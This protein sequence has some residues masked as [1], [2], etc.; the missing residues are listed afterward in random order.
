MGRVV[1][2][3]MLEFEG[4]AFSDCHVFLCSLCLLSP[5][6]HHLH[7]VSH[8]AVPTGWG[9][10][11]SY[12]WGSHMTLWFCQRHCRLS[13]FRLDSARLWEIPTF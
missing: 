13:P 6:V 9:L 10:R 5:H 7:R 12:C 3:G 11:L 1:S 8:N 2:E 4:E